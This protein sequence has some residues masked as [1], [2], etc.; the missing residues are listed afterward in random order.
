M[1]CAILAVQVAS[2]QS[3][4]KKP[5]AEPSDFFPDDQ[6]RGFYDAGAPSDAVLDALLKTPEAKLNWD[7]LQ[8]LNRG[9]LRRLFL[10]VRVHLK[11]ASET[12]EVVL[13]KYP[14]S[15]ADCF[16]FWFVRDLG[17]HASVLLFTNA[18]GV[19][20]LKSRTNDY[21]DIRSVWSSA[22]GY[23]LTDVYHYDGEQY[24]L[25]HHFEKQD[26]QTP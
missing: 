5:T 9:E 13:G 3:K 22:A 11:D 2:T 1:I 24:R 10:V 17:D 15:G 12:D 23:T 21:R 26:K 18:Y 8:R 19:Y 14:M 4:V 20:L 7:R 6:N 25:A 16:W